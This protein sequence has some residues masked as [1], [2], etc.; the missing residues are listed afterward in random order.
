MRGPDAMAGGRDPKKDLQRAGGWGGH[1]AGGVA[2]ARGGP[3]GEGGAVFAPTVV[4]LIDGLSYTPNF[5]LCKAGNM[6]R[7]FWLKKDLNDLFFG[8]IF[9]LPVIFFSYI[10]L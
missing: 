5:A 6:R 8:T 10:Y 7:V 3:R 9:E 4:T 2:R 1:P